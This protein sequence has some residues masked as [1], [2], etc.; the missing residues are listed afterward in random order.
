MALD[1]TTLKNDLKKILEGMR[2]ETANVDDALAGKLAS[3]ID[4][5]IKTADI[6]SGI[7]VSTAGSAAAQTG[8]TVAT[9]K[10]V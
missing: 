4:K 1:K 5:Y 7:A 9:A 2:D 3:A 8:A 10:L 6:P